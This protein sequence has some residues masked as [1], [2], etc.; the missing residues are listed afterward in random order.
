MMTEINNSEINN[1]FNPQKESTVGPVIGSII[2]ILMII[3][4]GFYFW[5]SILENT[6]DKKVQPESVTEQSIDAEVSEIE[7]EIDNLD[8]N[9]IDSEL[10]QIE[11]EIDAE[12]N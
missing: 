12:L 8:F 6:T 7:S 5:G 2:I 1:Q 3:L 9:Q 10:E 4:G 11:S